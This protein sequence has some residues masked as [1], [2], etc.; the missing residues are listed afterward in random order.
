MQWRI[1]GLSALNLNIGTYLIIRFK[2]RNKAWQ[3]F[4]PTFKIAK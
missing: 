2:W 1:I 3:P 4:D